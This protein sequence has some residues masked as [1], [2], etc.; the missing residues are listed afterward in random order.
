MTSTLRLFYQNVRGI[1]TKTSD[2]YQSVLNSNYDVLV[3]TETWLNNSIVSNEFVDGRYNVFRRD[4]ETTSSS[5]LDGGGVLIAVS[6]RYKCYRVNSWETNSEDLWINII[7]GTKTISIC[8][9]YLPPPLK[10]NT[11]ENFIQN[12]EK[13]MSK[14]SLTVI[15][16][17]FNLPSI[18]WISDAK[19]KNI[20]IP[21]DFN[22]ISSL[23]SDFLC[24]SGL[25]QHNCITNSFG[26]T[27]DLVFSNVSNITVEDSD[28]SVCKVDKYHPP[29]TVE[30]CH[31]NEPEIL[32]TPELT[33]RFNFM[34]ADY[35]TI[36]KKLNNIIWTE[37]FNKCITL[38]QMIDIFYIELRKIIE[39]SVP[40]YTSKINNKYPVWYSKQLIKRLAEKNKY[41]IWYK[42]YKNPLDKIEFEL[43]RTRC[44]TIINLDYN[45]YLQ[46]VEDNIKINP[47]YFHSYLKKI[48]NNKCDYP[49]LMQFNDC[50]FTNGR[51]ICNQF[52]VHFANTYQT[53]DNSTLNSYTNI[54]SNFNL[55]LANV[56]ID[57]QE[58][59]DQL[60][61][62]KIYKGAGPD[63]IPPIFAKKCAKSLANPLIIIF[64]KSLEDGIFPSLWKKA[65]V[66]PIFKSGDKKDITKYRPI[67]IL[68]VFSKI[69]EVIMCRSLSW[70]VKPFMIESQHGFLKNRSTM[71]NLVSFINDVSEVLDSNGQVDCIYTDLAKAFDVVDHS[72][73]IHKLRNYGI[74]GKVINWIT[75]YLDNRELNVVIGGHQ[76]DTF[77]ATS[78]VPQGSHLGPIL[79]GIF[80]NDI[81]TCFDN[82]RI[83]LYADDLK[84]FK[85]ISSIDDSIKM[86]ADLEKLVSW[87]K[88]NNLNLNHQKCYS[89]TFSRK[90]SS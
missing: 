5:R 40:K 76:S 82:C 21:S 85:K 10:Q 74:C 80:I 88:H 20:L 22:I 69:F 43:L 59:I 58:I 38:N 79:F 35:N 31:D 53:Y 71:T 24:V 55:Q 18:K 44:Q 47:K 81:I 86:Q 28:F 75:S 90:T 51:D 54:N 46:T 8:G 19:C 49:A 32:L 39:E 26:K 16:G 73:L 15:V 63:N 67:C 1:R 12:T 36:N 17:D 13:F 33:V 9:V 70:Y 23:I 83:F 34:K 57:K 48:R 72:V 11:I 89:I 27:L 37:L 56:S 42:K 3:F 14:Q 7:L 61:K 41:R 6:K 84:M 2:V 62:L 65:R 64:H 50:E 66:V 25:K 60:E 78:G 4:R 30:I 77:I 29:L 45:N 52:A 68:S 87:C